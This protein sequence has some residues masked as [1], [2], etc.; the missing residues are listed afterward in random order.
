MSRRI[1][2]S[3]ALA[4]GFMNIAV[5]QAQCANQSFSI[6]FSEFPVA[7]A[8]NNQYLDKGVVF[9]SGQNAALIAND[10]STPTSPVLSGVP[11]F[12]GPITAAFVQP[13]SPTANTVA[14]AL[15]FSAG[16]F[17]SVNSTTVVWQDIDNNTI[18]TASNTGTGIQT[19][20]APPNT[21]AFTIASGSDSAGFVI[22]N[23]SYTLGNVSDL[24][25]AS[26]AKDRQGALSQNEF[27][28][29]DNIAFTAAGPAAM[30]QVDWEVTMEYDTE[31]PRGMPG[32]TTALQTTGTGSQALYY[33][34]RGGRGRVAAKLASDPAVTACPIEYFYVVGTPIPDANVTARLV[35]L[36]A[37]G[38][39]PR[40]LTGIAYKES[41]YR[42][43]FTKTKYGKSAPWPNESYDGGSH[44]GLMQVATS[45]STI[46]GSQ[47]VSNAWDW[48]ANTKF[49]EALFRE[50]LALALSRENA[51]R[52]S[53]PSLRA[54]TGVEREN[55]ALLLYGPYSSGLILRQYYVPAPAP[56]GGLQWVVNT[57]GNAAGVQYADQVR[58]SIQ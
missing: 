48:Q 26:P 17:D 25:I 15:S 57:N 2:A 20:T 33:Q 12:E 11:R 18:G 9:A 1:L 6:T 46:S 21:H 44:V 53:R 13:S 24:R 27:T 32:L 37:D 55:M 54:L 19:F 29:S 7:T 35:S 58:S 50:K 10:S 16:Y 45:G 52:A 47:G 8:V 56:G 40:L 49:G 42:Q 30:G 39:T 43:F 31:T 34:S 41:T 38:A 5:V 23:L 4:L 3:S 14:N 36:Y 22:D 51:M 28:R